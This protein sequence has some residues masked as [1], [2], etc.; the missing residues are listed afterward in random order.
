MVTS[1]ETNLK[2]AIRRPGF[3]PMSEHDVVLDHINRFLKDIKY[4]YT[5]NG[6]G[7]HQEE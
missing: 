7:V 3:G 4:I 6:V 1:T 5:I 2:L